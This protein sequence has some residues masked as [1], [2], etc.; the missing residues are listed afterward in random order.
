MEN[1]AEVSNEKSGS[2]LKKIIFPIILLVLIGGSAWYAYSKYTFSQAHVETDNAQIDGFISP[3]IVRVPGYVR[4]IYFEE[5]KPVKEG[6]IILQLDDR[7]FKIRLEQ[8]MAGLGASKANVDVS[9]T[10]VNVTK[11]GVNASQ[12]N[13]AA[14]KQN[15]LS[16][17][18]QIQGAQIRVDATEK[19]F[20]RFSNLLKEGATTQQVYDRV[21]T[22]RDAALVQLK[23]AQ[24]QYDVLV[25]Q[26]AAAE[27][28]ANVT[29][30][31]VGTSESQV[32]LANT[33]LSAREL[34]IELMKLNLSYTMVTAPISGTLARKSIQQGQF[35][36]GGQTVY[37][38]VSDSIYVTANFKETQLEK[39]KLGQKAI[40]E[41]DAFPG[42]E[43]EGE[44]VSLSPATGA[45][46]SLIP[47]D[48]A[49]GN[50]TKVVQRVPVKLTIKVPDTLK[51]KL[52]PGM[53]VK[54]TVKI[55]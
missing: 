40:I 17:K 10:G 28:Q 24:N 4:N 41:V 42:I 25:K 19:E 3:V 1:T 47:P 34:D 13:V 35:V 49:T 12:A 55:A 51:S 6:E 33:G 32:A 15:L 50:Y 20:Q 54:V 29:A 36:Q 8:A 14:I 22:E 53:S 37:S 7:E 5:N 27:N 21:K 31:Q 23:V 9:R 16:A 45:K 2:N 52:K 44:I 18:E 30:Q 39:M 48:N 43:I 46:F 11:A 38:V 26:V